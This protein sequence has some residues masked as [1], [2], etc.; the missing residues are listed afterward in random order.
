[1]STLHHYDLFK[2][3]DEIPVHFK[4]YVPPHRVKVSKE[5]LG[6]V[7]RA[8]AVAMPPKWKDPHGIVMQLVLCRSWTRGSYSLFEEW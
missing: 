6:A 5:T 3:P 1:M 2:H 4:F 8:L 7:Y